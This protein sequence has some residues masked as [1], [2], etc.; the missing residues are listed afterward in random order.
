MSTIVV[1]LFGSICTITGGSVS[2]GPPVGVI[3]EAHFVSSAAPKSSATAVLN[4]DV[5]RFMLLFTLICSLLWLNVVCYALSI[6]RVLLLGWD[7]WLAWLIGELVHNV[8]AVGR[9]A[10]AP[11]VEV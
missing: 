8:P 3:V 9:A 4:A 7:K 10:L 6:F 1:K 11:G 2:F 5:T